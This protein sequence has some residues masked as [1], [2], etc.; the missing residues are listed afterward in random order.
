MSGFS[1]ADL[2]RARLDVAR[3]DLAAASDCIAAGHFRA[4]NNRA[5]FAI[6]HAIRAVLVLDGVDFNE[7]DRAVG[8]FYDN[9]LSSNILDGYLKVVIDFALDSSN[10]GDYED[11]YAATREEA[12]RNIGGAA[13]VL[14]A[15]DGHLVSRLE[16]GATR[17]DECP[18][19]LPQSS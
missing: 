7:H 9:Y 6:F 1:R 10:R 2:S 12:A 8:Y 17:V 18:R 5:Y 4:A 19:K 15:V 14:R 11:H 13:D 3:E 16:P